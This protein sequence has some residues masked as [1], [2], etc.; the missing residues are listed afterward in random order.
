[1]RDCLSTQPPVSSFTQ[2]SGNFEW[3]NMTGIEDNV[4]CLATES[5]VPQFQLSLRGWFA[6]G[7]RSSLAPGTHLLFSA[8]S[9]PVDPQNSQPSTAP[10]HHGKG[11]RGQTLFRVKQ[12]VKRQANALH[13]VNF[14]I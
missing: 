7:A 11:G 5:G 2:A 3:W 8:G 10:S 12:A 6:H 14:A 9:D 13:L 4:G 1:M